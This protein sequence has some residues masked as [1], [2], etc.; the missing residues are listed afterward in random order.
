MLHHVDSARRQGAL[1]EAG[2]TAH[3]HAVLHAMKLAFADRAEYLGDSDFTAVP[4]ARLTDAKVA[5]ARWDASFSPSRATAVE[6]MSLAEA[7]REGMHTTHLSAIDSEG[8]AVAMTVTVNDNFG[9]GFVPPGTGVVMNNEMDDFAAQPGVPNLFGL[10]GAEAN[11]VAAGKRPLSSM[12]P[13]IVRDSGGSVRLVLGAQGGP[14]ILTAVFQ[15]IVNRLEFGLSLPD[16]AGAARVHHQW[17]PDEAYV[18]SP[19]TAP[20]ILKGLE[21][22]GYVVRKTTGVG[23]LQAI[24]RFADG[25]VWGVPDPRTEGG[26]AAE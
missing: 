16:A 12:T 3:Q 1:G 15:T 2:S 14:R 25:R 17:K 8:G 24:E 22:M 20:E 26:A 11:A 21:A 10:V 23:R 9:S 19:G 5:S 4:L 7:P 13:T 6:P 18:E